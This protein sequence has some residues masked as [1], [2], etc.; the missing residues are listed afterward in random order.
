MD[1]EIGTK[2]V[3]VPVRIIN[4]RKTITKS[5]RWGSV[6]LFI[7]C[8]LA[9]V[10]RAWAIDESGPIHWGATHNK[11]D[12]KLNVADLEGNAFVA[13]P[14]ETL[15]ADFIHLDLNARTLDARGHCIYVANSTVIDGEEM[16]F[17]LDTRTGT[18]VEGRVSTDKFSLSGERINKLGAN[19]FQAHWGE[20]STC[21]DCPNSWSFQGEDVDLEIEGYAYLSNVTTKIKDAPTFWLPY[22]VVPI[23]TKRQTGLLFPKLSL[24]SNNGAV[25]VQPFFWAINDSADLTLGLGTYARRGRRI[26][27][28]GRYALTPRSRAQIN[29]YHLADST[30]SLGEIPADGL[31]RFALDIAQTQ[32]LPF[33][34]EEKLRLTEVS[35]NRYARDIGDGLPSDALD[36]PSTLSFSYA[37]SDVSSFLTFNRYRN[38]LPSAPPFSPYQ[39]TDK[40]FDFTKVQLIPGAVVTSNDQFLF[41]SSI[42]TGLTVGVSNFTRGADFYDVDTNL[43]DLDAGQASYPIIRKATRVSITP[44]LYTT[45]RPFDKFA[46]VPSLQYRGYFYSFNNGVANLSRGYLLFQTDLSTQIERIYSSDDPLVPKSKHLIRPIL[47][48]SVIPYTLAPAHPFL[49]QIAQAQRHNITGYNF[50]DNDIVPED[51]SP[52]SINY[53]NPLGNSITYGVTTELI[54]KRI[55][56]TSNVA[57]YERTVEFSVGQTFDLNELWHPEVD[58]LSRLASSLTFVIDPKINGQFYYYFYPNGDHLSRHQFSSSLNYYFERSF[59]QR[60]LVYER[61][62][63]LDYTWD[64]TNCVSTLNSCGTDQLSLR[65][66]FSLNDYIMPTLR[67]SYDFVNHVFTSAHADIRFQ[68]PSQCWSVTFGAEYSQ[69]L[70]GT[71]YGGDVSLNLT[72][73]GFNGVSGLTQQTLSH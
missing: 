45:L 6:A 47:N 32:V 43:Q 17:N 3:L 53:F 73:S 72:G 42:A 48:Y 51:A 33:G 39:L 14:G 28:E 4:L 26:E 2:N 64:Q 66:S 21:R 18:I 56:P 22:L 62:A 9:T 52:T 30:F 27:F 13:Q 1:V 11:W 38:L 49:Q 34:I 69:N 15:T 67:G 59:H 7:A 19:R 70:A 46:L 60:I 16:H 23:K 71:N 40:D 12:R 63:G 29:L 31:N 55:N 58:L 44:S 41:N 10:P 24:S 57:G 65:G 61:S 50:D 54:R 8:I 68:S 36:L 37:S 35:D 5:L 20:Y 25:Y